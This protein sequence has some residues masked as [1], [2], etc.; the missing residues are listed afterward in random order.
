MYIS[1]SGYI[2]P[3]N[4]LVAVNDIGFNHSTSLLCHND[5]D[6][7]T[8]CEIDWF[9]PNGAR[10]TDTAKPTTT[11]NTVVGLTRNTATAMEGIYHCAICDRNTSRQLY[12]GIY[13][14]EAGN[15][16]P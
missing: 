6:S 13:P 7:E 16:S 3:D 10:I 4:G 8:N 12:V 15:F 5:G 11:S 2:I 1:L 14:R 9:T